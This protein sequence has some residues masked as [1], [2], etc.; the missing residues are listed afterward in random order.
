M[1]RWWKRKKGVVWWRKRKPKEKL[2]MYS[3]AEI[4]AVFNRLGSCPGCTSFWRDMVMAKVGKFLIDTWD[5]KNPTP[6]SLEELRK[7]CCKYEGQRAGQSM[8]VDM[9]QL[10]GGQIVLG[11]PLR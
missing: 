5:G 3:E 6:P 10:P 8:T 1:F 9:S 7:Y 2:P 11:E 4:L